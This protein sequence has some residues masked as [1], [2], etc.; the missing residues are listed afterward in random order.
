VD[1]IPFIFSLPS[2]ESF[3]TTFTYDAKGDTWE[4]LMENH[5]GSEV[6]PFA[7]VRLTRKK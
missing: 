5:Q 3:H 6:I 4:W 1:K 7:L 2:G